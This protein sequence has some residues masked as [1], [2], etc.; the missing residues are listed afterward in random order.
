MNLEPFYRLLHYQSLIVIYTIYNLN[1]YVLKPIIL[2]Q[3]G[4]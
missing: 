3:H 4:G 1:K 2:A